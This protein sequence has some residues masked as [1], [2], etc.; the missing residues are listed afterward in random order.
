[1]AT[2]TKSKAVAKKKKGGALSGPS[3]LQRAMAMAGGAGNEAL[4]SADL[5]IPFLKILQDL[6]PQT[7]KRDEEY[8]DGAEPGMFFETVSRTLWDGDE[9]LVAVPCHYLSMVNE[10]VKR[11]E[12]GG[13]VASH[14]DMPT[15]ME[16]CT[17][18]DKHDLID[19]HQHALMVLLPNGTWTQCIFPMKSSALKASRQWN[20]LVNGREGSFVDEDGI[21][22]TYELPRF[23]ATWRLKTAE[24]TNDSGTF[25][26]PRTPEL[27]MTLE[28]MG[29]E[30][31]ALFERAFDF[32][33][34][35]VAGEAK[36]DYRK[37]DE[38]V[39]VED[40][41]DIDGPGF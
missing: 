11:T 23:F 15:A 29:E 4:T 24:R 18:H 17:D 3:E 7:K 35:C 25:F 12:G 27:E 38:A 9:G 37:M 19:T 21:T 40:D 26:V 13:F 32:Y 16:H 6:S 5:A 1:M 33:R 39:V 8:V 10:W 36:V 28:D 22:Q 14:R 20:S 31:E 41:E 30:G 2:A 34:Q